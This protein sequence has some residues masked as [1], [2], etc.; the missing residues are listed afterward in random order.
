MEKS[1]QIWRCPKSS[2]NKKIIK[3][4]RNRK[5][6]IDAKS[7]TNMILHFLC[8][9]KSD[10]IYFGS[11]DIYRIFLDNCDSDVLSVEDSDTYPDYG[12]GSESLI[13][14]N[15]IRSS[16][17]SL[18]SM[19]YIETE[20]IDTIPEVFNKD[21]VDKRK[22]RTRK[23]SEKFYKEYRDEQYDDWELYTLPIFESIEIEDDPIEFI[24]LNPSPNYP[25]LE[26]KNGTITSESHGQIKRKEFY[27]FFRRKSMTTGT[28]FSITLKY[29][30]EMPSK[31]FIDTVPVTTK[32]ESSYAVLLIT[33][34][35]KLIIDGYCK[36]EDLNPGN[37]LKFSK[38]KNEDSFLL[39]I[40]K[41]EIK[42]EKRQ[43]QAKIWLGSPQPP[44]DDA[45]E[46]NI[47]A[48]MMGDGF[49]SL[50]WPAFQI[51]L[52]H[53]TREQIEL[54][55]NKIESSNK[56]IV[57]I[58]VNFSVKMEIGEIIIAKKGDNPL[59][60]DKRI[61]GIGLINSEYNYDENFDPFGTHNSH[62]R[63]VN[64]IINFYE[65]NKNGILLEPFIDLKDYLED[66]KVF[67]I[68]TLVRKDFEFYLKVKDAIITKLY[69]LK[70]S[71]VLEEKEYQ[72]YLEKFEELEVYLDK[73]EK[74]VPKTK[75]VQKI[76]FD[77]DEIKIEG[78]FFENFEELNDR[79]KTALKNGKHI[80]LIG[81]PGTGKSKLAKEVCKFYCDKDNYVMSTA[82]SEWST[83]ETIG[84]YRPNPEKNGALEFY[85][86]FF[87]QCF[88][89]KTNS[90]INKWL[91]IDEINR[92][93]IDKAFGS[94]F[95]AL[96]GDNITLPY[97]NSEGP[98]KVVSN[99]ESNDFEKDNFFIIPNEWRII[100]TMNTFDKTSLYEMSYAFMRRFAFIPVDVPL[101]IDETLIYKYDKIWN[102]NLNSDELSNIADLWRT[103][104]KYRKVGPAIIEDICKDI[105]I[106]DQYVSALI[107]YVLPQFEGLLDE[108]IINFCLESKKKD[109]M[110]D[111][112]KL[113][114]FASEFFEIEKVKFKK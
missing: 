91:I 101:N 52:K 103:I 62:Y 74:P 111:T 39:E 64:W 23:R 34:L 92:A 98:I 12:Y 68:K 27:D 108:R 72:M 43:S 93:D 14:Q 17:N 105:K 97:E 76:D 109:Y 4:S 33:Y 47:F 96:T 56:D 44:R 89:D 22:R 9:L 59:N 11:T 24:I 100:A 30:V 88:K 16:L 48:K 67:D 90:N 42:F 51:N 94:L 113:M 5:N 79:I 60:P 66:I 45:Y 25:F 81:P 19:N 35:R 58:H 38:I 63:E 26:I 32:G 1:D 65:D 86:G 6:I 29:I 104:N 114:N 31:I 28:N 2:C 57:N 71:N 112:E 107:M 82:T 54:A 8:H 61:Y 18:R 70:D 102:V 7:Y 3:I 75:K 69:E 21:I 77:I 40:E 87:L 49:F 73:R 13:W 84:G 53:L 83:F 50:G 10:N 41:S 95:S 20:D 106:T 110:K 99:P 46:G 15:Q 78:L 55:F 36:A 37:L 85:P 80:I